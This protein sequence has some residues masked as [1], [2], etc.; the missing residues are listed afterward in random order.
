[1]GSKIIE[2]LFHQVCIINN[3]VKFVKNILRHTWWYVALP[4]LVES[5]GCFGQKDTFFILCDL[6]GCL[7]ELGTC[8]E[9]SGHLATTSTN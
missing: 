9:F 5:A 8:G 4:Q 3:L 6:S 7:F 2:E 1:M